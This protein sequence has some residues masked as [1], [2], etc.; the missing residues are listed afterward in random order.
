MSIKNIILFLFALVVAP[1]LTFNSIA[2]IESDFENIFFGDLKKSNN[3]VRSFQKTKSGDL[4]CV[5]SNHPVFVNFSRKNTRFT[6]SFIDDFTLPQSR[7]IQFKG[8]GKNAN[9]INYTFLGDNILG[10][11]SQSTLLHRGPSFYFHSINPHLKEKTNHGQPV[12]I[13]N[14]RY[15]DIDYSRLAMVSKEDAQHAAI[16]Y[17]PYTKPDEHT[18]M[19]YAVFNADFSIPVQHE[20]IFEYASRAFKPI[21]F[22]IFNQEEQLFITGHYPKGNQMR[23]TSFF[24]EIGVHHLK[25]NQKTT[26]LLRYPNILFTDVQIY[27]EEEG[28]LLKGLYTSTTNGGVEG[29]YIARLTKNGNVEHHTFSPFSSLVQERIRE[30]RNIQ[31]S[32]TRLSQYETSTFNILEHYSV[33]DGYISVIEFNALEYRYGGAD[34]PGSTSTIDTYYWSGDLIVSKTGKDGRIIWSKI[35]PKAQRTINDGGYYLSTAIYLADNYLHLF[36]NDSQS[37]YKDGIYHLDSEHPDFAR[38]GNANNTVAHVSIDLTDGVVQ[39]KSIIGKSETKVLFVPKLSLPVK[40]Q[41]KMYIYTVDG[42]K[43]RLGSITFSKRNTRNSNKD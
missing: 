35:I 23:E 3:S 15:N 36:F 27:P 6:F 43:H 26:S 5:Q 40:E 24:E 17:L 28:I 29:I 14:S 2:Q 4:L 8:V 12:S 32:T 42:K 19:K 38:F 11:S 25:S 1:S 30:F 39:R 13:F 34:M 9:L 18:L 33:K 7:P 16:L 31:S 20:L 21:D 37:N 41:N 22:H 10:L